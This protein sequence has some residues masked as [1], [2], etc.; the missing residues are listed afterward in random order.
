MAKDYSGNAAPGVSHDINDDLKNKQRTYLQ[1][2]LVLQVRNSR[3]TVSKNG[4]K[5][6]LN[7]H[8]QY[9]KIGYTFFRTCIICEMFFIYNFLYNS[10]ELVT[11]WET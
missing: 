5:I 7:G 3:H 9:L 2:V 4:L 11:Q 6:Q 1:V 8:S 10:T